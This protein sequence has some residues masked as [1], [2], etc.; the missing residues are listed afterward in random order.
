M[1]VLHMHSCSLTV[2]MGLYAK[3]WV[4]T[5]KVEN[6]IFYRR[7]KTTTLNQMFDLQASKFQ[8][9]AS[10]A[11][12]LTSILVAF[13][14]FG[15]KAGPFY[16]VCNNSAM[17]RFLYKFEFLW[18]KVQCSGNKNMGETGEG[19]QTRQLLSWPDCFRVCLT[20]TLFMVGSNVHTAE[21]PFLISSFLSIWFWQW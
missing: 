7:A 9:N 17:N 4:N 3:G 12:H 20:E 16:A 21:V 15:F 19:A 11:Q 13:Q 5:H 8:W 6:H 1:T 18:L 10:Q 2:K 14:T